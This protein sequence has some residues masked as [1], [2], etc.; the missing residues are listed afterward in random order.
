M[1][2]CNSGGT[3]IVCGGTA[4]FTCPQGTYCDLGE[5]CGGFDKNGICKYIP[6]D[7]PNDEEPVCSCNKINYQ[8]P[9]YANGSAETIAYKGKCI[10][11]K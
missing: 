8:N 2:A 11:S 4:N 6:Q 10:G 9:C 3:E 7:C 5:N 1:S